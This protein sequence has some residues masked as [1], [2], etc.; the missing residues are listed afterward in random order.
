MGFSRDL[1]NIRRDSEGPCLLSTV[2]A[3]MAVG[4]GTRGLCSLHTEEERHSLR[5]H[6]PARVWGSG[7]GPTPA[8]R[9]MQEE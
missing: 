8:D 3:D 4:H 5:E 6:E 1:H 9:R 7:F 2:M